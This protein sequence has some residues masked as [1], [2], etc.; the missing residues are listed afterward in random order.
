[1][2]VPPAFSTDP[3]RITP[4]DDSVIDQV[5][6]DARDVYVERF[7]LPVLGPT[8]TFVL[9]QFADRFDRQPQGFSL[10]IDEIAHTVGLSHKAGR[11]SPVCKAIDRLFHYRIA[12]PCIG[13]RPARRRRPPGL[14]DGMTVRRR[15]PPIARRMIDRFPP[16]LREHHAV[17]LSRHPRGVVRVPPATA[18]QLARTLLSL[19]EDPVD[20]RRHLRIMRQPDEV[21]DAVA[22]AVLARAGLA[23]ATSDR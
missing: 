20:I 8:A 10:T 13:G 22:G 4:W 7:W 12:Q 9:R 16:A 19:G 1:M 3:L 21:V 17:H 15:L 6:F 23:R 5:G 2:S 18:E 11:S 14:V